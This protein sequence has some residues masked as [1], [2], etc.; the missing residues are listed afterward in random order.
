MSL[1]FIVVVPVYLLSFDGCRLLVSVFRF[2]FVVVVY[3]LS[4]DGCRLL[5]SVSRFP[6][7][8]CRCRLSLSFPFIVC[9]LKVVAALLLAAPPSCVAVLFPP[10]RGDFPRSFSCP[11]PVFSVVLLCV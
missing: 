1:S 3:R 6:F 4:F 2:A 8:V 5:V 7:R 10:F 9:R 11:P